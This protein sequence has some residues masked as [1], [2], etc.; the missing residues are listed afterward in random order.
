MI[1]TYP[2]IILKLIKLGYSA[3]LY[4]Q[5][6]NKKYY[7]IFK[8]QSTGKWLHVLAVMYQIKL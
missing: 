8:K 4:T 3:L 7:S 2:D 6:I 1:L 5:P